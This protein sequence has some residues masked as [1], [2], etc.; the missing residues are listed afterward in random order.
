VVDNTKN[1]FFNSFFIFYFFALKMAILEFFEKHSQEIL[2]I[3]F[4]QV[5]TSFGPTMKIDNLGTSKLGQYEVF[6]K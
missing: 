2:R 1:L 3:N 6:H 5:F 4:I